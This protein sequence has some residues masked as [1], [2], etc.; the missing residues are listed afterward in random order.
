MTE[1]FKMD[2]NIIFHMLMMI[3]E[4]LSMVS[5]DIE[6]SKDSNKTS[7]AEKCTQWH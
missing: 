7:V 6:H 2:I 5:K 1:L 4:I 3:E